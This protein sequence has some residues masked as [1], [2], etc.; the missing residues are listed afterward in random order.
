MPGHFEPH[1]AINLRATLTQSGNMFVSV[2][3]LSWGVQI[4]VGE[5][6]MGNKSDRIIIDNIL[7][8]KHMHM[9]CIYAR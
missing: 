5:A 9:P 3:F 2:A 4:D 6:I 7:L 1:N 8:A